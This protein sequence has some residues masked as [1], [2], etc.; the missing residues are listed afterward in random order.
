MF[1]I[2][3]NGTIIYSIA[4]ARNLKVIFDSSLSLPLL[5]TLKNLVLLIEHAKHFSY[6]YIS[7]YPY[8][9]CPSLSHSYLSTRLL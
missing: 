6:L 9:G 4:Q 7:L 8:Y 5:H 1:S 2:L 3:V